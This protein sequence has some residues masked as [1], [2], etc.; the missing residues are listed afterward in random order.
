MN[1]V[2]NKLAKLSAFIEASIKAAEAEEETL[3]DG[4]VYTLRT[5]YDNSKNSWKGNIE[6]L[7]RFTDDLV[8]NVGYNFPKDLFL[9]G[10]KTLD[11]TIDKRVKLEIT[12]LARL[13]AISQTIIENGGIHIEEE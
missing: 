4:F 10:F 2:L 12:K 6:P 11:D 3:S 5:T 9:M 7:D 1:D 13:M 8:T